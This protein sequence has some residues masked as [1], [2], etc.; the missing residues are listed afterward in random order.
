MLLTSSSLNSRV[1]L[2][3]VIVN[4]SSEISSHLRREAIKSPVGTVRMKNPLLIKNSIRKSASS[5]SVGDFVDS[6]AAT[7]I[8][9]KMIPRTSGRMKAP[10]L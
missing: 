5:Y 2:R 3:S 4:E 1:P 8:P 9:R 7:P 6:T 10:L